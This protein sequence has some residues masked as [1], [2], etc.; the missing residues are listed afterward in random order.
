MK[1]LTGATRS[2]EAPLTPVIEG[3][4]SLTEPGVAPTPGDIQVG[5]LAP[6]R[7]SLEQRRSESLDQSVRPR[8]WIEWVEALGLR[9]GRLLALRR[10]LTCSSQSTF[11]GVQIEFVGGSLDGSSEGA[12]PGKATTLVQAAKLFRLKDRILSRAL[13]FLRF[14]YL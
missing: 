10:P 1:A 13:S 7:R 2:H 6:S 5:S 9:V 12:Q 14:L 4:V 8:S 11:G 3:G